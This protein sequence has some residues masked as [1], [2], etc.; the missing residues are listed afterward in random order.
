MSYPTHKINFVNGSLKVIAY[1]GQH[2][3]RKSFL[4]LCQCDC[5]NQVILPTDKLKY[6]K[7]CK[8]HPQKHGLTKRNQKFHP[9]YRMW[10]NIKKRCY[11]AEPREYKY[12]QGKGIKVC[13]EWLNDA[14]VFYNW[15]MESG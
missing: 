12:Y 9:L 5:G 7:Q 2:E 4:W 6:T 10:C 14:K 11:S 13:D 15:A 3:K 8:K 1:H